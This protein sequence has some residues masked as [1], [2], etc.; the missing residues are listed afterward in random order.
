LL[1]AI[2]TLRFY[3]DGE[4]STRQAIHRGGFGSCIELT[5]GIRRSVDARVPHSRVTAGH[6]CCG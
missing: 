4:A 3:S 1:A 6:G 5:T 2:G